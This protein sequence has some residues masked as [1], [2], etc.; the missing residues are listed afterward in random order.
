MR[1]TPLVGIG[2]GGD[3]HDGALHVAAILLGIP[4]GLTKAPAPTAPFRR[5][6]RDAGDVRGRQRLTRLG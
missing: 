2:A 1:I 5:S 3:R 4:R 6:T